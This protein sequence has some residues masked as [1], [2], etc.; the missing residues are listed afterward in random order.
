MELR[1]ASEGPCVW[2]W[3]CREIRILLPNDQRQ[4]RTLHFSKVVLHS[5]PLPLPRHA[6]APSGS[7]LSQLRVCV[8]SIVYHA[9]DFEWISNNPS[10]IIPRTL[11]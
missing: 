6:V 9:A 1:Q 3:S 4:H 5:T 8:K 10:A 7:L 11:R 2:R